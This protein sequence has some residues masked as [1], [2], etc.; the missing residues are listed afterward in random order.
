MKNNRSQNFHEIK[1]AFLDIISKSNSQLNE[2]IINI[3]PNM[4][5]FIQ[6][7]IKNK[8]FLLVILKNQEKNKFRIRQIETNSDNEFKISRKIGSEYKEIQLDDFDS[9]DDALDMIRKIN[10]RKF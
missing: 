2:S 10:Q 5:Y 6:L 8:D 3:L 7:N 4:E 9:L 1:G